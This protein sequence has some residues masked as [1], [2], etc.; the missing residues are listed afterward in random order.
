MLVDAGMVPVDAALGDLAARRRHAARARRLRDRLAG[1]AALA[2]D[3]LVLD[4][5]GQAVLGDARRARRRADGDSRRPS[6]S[7]RPAA[8]SSRPDSPRCSVHFGGVQEKPSSSET[9][10]TMFLASPDGLT[11]VRMKQ[12]RRPSFR[13]SS[14]RLLV[15]DDRGRIVG[16]RRVVFPVVAAVVRA[17]QRRARRL[18]LALLLVAVDAAVEA[19]EDR[20]VRQLPAAEPAAA[21]LERPHVDGDRLASRSCRRPST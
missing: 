14:G 8:R 16:Q 18:A 20:A 12:T 13:R 21:M 1:H 11:W 10:I 15:V 5:P 9:T 17:H 19:H 7:D 3:E 2:D 4:V 6:G